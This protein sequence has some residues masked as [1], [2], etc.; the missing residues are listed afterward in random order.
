MQNFDFLSDSPRIFIFKKDS[1]KTN[2]GGILFLIYIAIMILISLAYILEYALNEKYSIENFA[3]FNFSRDGNEEIN[4]N[5]DIELN[6]YLDINVTFSD[7]Y[8]YDILAV[9]TNLNRGIK[10]EFL[11]EKFLC[12]MD[13]LFIIISLEKKLILQI[14]QFLLDVSKIVIVLCFMTLFII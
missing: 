4:L 10:N 9:H 2:F 8:Y 1:N 6:P 5:E 3:V 13:I 11:E 12:K 7:G 14:L